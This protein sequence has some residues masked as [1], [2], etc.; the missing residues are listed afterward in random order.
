MEHVSFT[1]R[2]DP[3]V[4]QEREMRKQ[5]EAARAKAAAEAKAGGSTG[6]ATT[7]ASHA[8][9]VLGAVFVAGMPT[10]W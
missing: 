8:L 6:S 9:A 5:E 3:K 2:V 10:R 4:A 7:L 1:V